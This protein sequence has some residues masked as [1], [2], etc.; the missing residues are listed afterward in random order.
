MDKLK[1]WW[2]RR[3]LNFYCWRILRND[4]K[5]IKAVFTITTIVGIPKGEDDIKILKKA[6]GDYNNAIESMDK[7]VINTAKRYVEWFDKEERD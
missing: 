5:I 1:F 3:K 2:L 7:N 6:I 4:I